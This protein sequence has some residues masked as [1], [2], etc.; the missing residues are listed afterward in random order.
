MSKGCVRIWVSV[1][2]LVSIV[3]HL[4]VQERSLKVTNYE[5]GENVTGLEMTLKTVHAEMH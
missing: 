2:D 3:L 4:K 5:F 1:H